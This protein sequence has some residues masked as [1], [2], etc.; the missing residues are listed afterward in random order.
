MDPVIQTVGMESR[1]GSSFHR[2]DLKD[3]KADSQARPG[4]AFGRRE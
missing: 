1:N 3:H 4:A 2:E